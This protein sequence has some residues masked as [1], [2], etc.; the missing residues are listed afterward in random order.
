MH[1]HTHYS[2]ESPF[3]SFPHILLV[4]TKFP[5]KPFPKALES[6]DRRSHLVWSND[7]E[8][9]CSTVL[10]HTW[11]QLDLNLRDGENLWA[12]GCV[13]CSSCLPKVSP[14]LVHCTRPA[15]FPTS[16]VITAVPPEATS[17]SW[18]RTRKCCCRASTTR[19]EKKM[20]WRKD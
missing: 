5:T 15:R 13:N 17:T 20:K 18:G 14:S 9:S 3:A 2:Y 12:Q 10:G 11:T 7:S 4:N 16:Q 8:I 6:K 19:P 1:F